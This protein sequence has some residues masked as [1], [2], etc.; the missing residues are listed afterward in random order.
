VPSEQSKLCCDMRKKIG[1]GI[2]K[3]FSEEDCGVADSV[4]A[5]Y[6][7]FGYESISQLPVQAALVLKY[8]PW[9]GQERAADSKRRVIEIIRDA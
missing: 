3:V 1:L 4:M 8:C 9:C 5:D 2:A 7:N 6:H